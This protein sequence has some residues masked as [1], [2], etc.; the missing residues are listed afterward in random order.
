M[1]LH[2]LSLINLKHFSLPENLC[3][4]ICMCMHVYASMYVRMFAYASEYECFHSTCLLYVSYN[5]IDKQ[6]SHNRT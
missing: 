3:M 1:L 5:K 4:R 6:I 2:T